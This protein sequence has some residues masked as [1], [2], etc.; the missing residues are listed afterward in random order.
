MISY[1]PGKQDQEGPAKQN[2]QYTQRHDD[3]NQPG[4][5]SESQSTQY[6]QSILCEGKKRGI[7]RSR[8]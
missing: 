5:F 6:V 7:G 8:A 4:Q 2:N 1:F 3:M